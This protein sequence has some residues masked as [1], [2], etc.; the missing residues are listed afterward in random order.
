MAVLIFLKANGSPRVSGMPGQEPWGKPGTGPEASHLNPKSGK[1]YIL[2]SSLL[3][4]PAW[5]V[6]TAPV[7]TRPAQR[8]PVVLEK[9]AASLP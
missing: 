9:T 3:Q 7:K 2:F 6:S 8:S 4:G 1:G 5:S